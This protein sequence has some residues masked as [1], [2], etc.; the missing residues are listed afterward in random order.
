[1]TVSIII[2]VYNEMRFIEELCDCL[3]AQT[4]PPGEMEI[5]FL[6]GRSEDG[7]REYLEKRD[8]RAHKRLIT[9]EKRKHVFALNLGLREARGT[10]LLRMDGHG[11][12]APDYV[13]KCV[14]LLESDENAINVGGV[15][16]A[17]GYDFGS[18]VIAKL[19]SSKFGGGSS[20]RHAKT[21]VK[22]DTLF[23]GAWR[24]E[25]LLKT[26]GWDESQLTSQDL[27]MSARFKSLFPGKYYLVDP[28]IELYYY[29]RN[30]VGKL[31]RQYYRYGYWR[32]FTV[33]K[34]PEM[35]RKS[36]Y[37]PLGLFATTA[38]G[39]IWALVFAFVFPPLLWLGFAPELAYL[40]YAGIA[41]ATFIRGEDH[42]IKRF[43]TSIAAFFALHYPWAFGYFRRMLESKILGK[44]PEDIYG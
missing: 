21:V 19:M 35:F 10:Y 25:Q 17:K 13:E 11:W 18:S 31:A 30:S 29:P 26:G 6:D 36:F 41:S 8:F 23:P 38:L 2:P 1:M 42:K 22:A 14:A 39:L 32:K 5:L 27:E 44:Q 33:D 7:T 12:Y 34:H 37:L 24:R 3:D 40:L 15:A 43:F 9:N 16:R 4:F 28:S 20:F